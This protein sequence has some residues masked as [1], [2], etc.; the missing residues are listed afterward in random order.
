[1]S[2]SKLNE[3]VTG[4]TLVWESIIQTDDFHGFPQLHQANF[5]IRNY[6]YAGKYCLFPH[7]LQ[8]I[9]YHANAA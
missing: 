1:M 6:P 8:F 5:G 9:I 3:A 4:V 2:L 7:P